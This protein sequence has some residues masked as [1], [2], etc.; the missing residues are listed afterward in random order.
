MV[1]YAEDELYSITEFAKKLSSIV[2]GI[3]DRQ[4]EKVG[5]LRNNRLEVVVISTQEYARLKEIESSR[6]RA[7]KRDKAKENSSKLEYLS[8]D[9]MAKKFNIEI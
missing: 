3:K 5:I 4:I 9:D 2:K 7:Q 6:K 8:I 1:K